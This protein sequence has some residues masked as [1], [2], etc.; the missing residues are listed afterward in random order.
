MLFLA[1]RKSGYAD[2]FLKW[3]WGKFISPTTASILRQNSVAY[4]ASFI[5]RSRS[6]NKA[7]LI[8]WL[9]R[10]CRWIHKYIDQTQ[11]SNSNMKSHAHGAFYSACQAVFYMIVFRQ[12]EFKDSK[13]ALD[14]ISRNG[15]QKVVTC[16]LNPLRY[17]LPAIV[18][19]FSSLAQY[20]QLAYCETII[21]KNR[22]LNLPIVGQ[23]EIGSALNASF[24]NV[25]PGAVLH[26]FFPFDPY[27][28]KHSKQFVSIHYRQ[29]VGN[30][31]NEEVSSSDEELTDED[32]E[33]EEGEADT[34]VSNFNDICDATNELA[35]I[36]PQQSKRQR[37]SSTS[38][39]VSKNL[40]EFGYSAFP[41]FKQ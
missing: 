37:L 29:Y 36:M 9:Q 14:K 27:T 19:N 8:C 34:L 2:A 21:Q 24:S 18:R 16:H 31:V 26:S 17:C 15:L 7:T 39:S 35:T 28:L 22:R 23:D 38:K 33:S 3:L 25:D 13:A 32:L 1:C 40:P 4:I 20:L 41:G 10:I 11:S 12:D 6:V 5:S 30:I